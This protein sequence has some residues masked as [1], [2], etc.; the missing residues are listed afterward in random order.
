MR[1]SLAPQIRIKT[2]KGDLKMC[3]VHS[4]V[5]EVFK[6]TQLDKMIEIKD[7]LET[8]LNS[9]KNTSCPTSSASSGL[10]SSIRPSRTIRA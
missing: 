3:R 7:D 1:D 5:R 6:I 10:A 8:A 2:E 9:F 4:E